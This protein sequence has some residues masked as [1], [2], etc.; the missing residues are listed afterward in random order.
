[1]QLWSLTCNSFCLLSFVPLIQIIWSL[2]LSHELNINSECFVNTDVHALQ[3]KSITLITKQ[4]ALC[5]SHYTAI[6]SFFFMFCWPCVSIHPCNENQLDTLF[7]LSLFRQSTST[8]FGH[9]FSPS[10]GGILYTVYTKQLVRVVL[11]SCNRQ[12]TKKH[13]TYQLLYIYNIPPDDG[14]QICPKH[15]EVDWRNK[16]RINS[17]S[18]WF[19]L[20]R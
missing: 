14:L 11:F 2:R 3:T 1:M 12:L 15:V 10:S 18:S 6:N 7:I 16:L 13:N 17:V 19:S 9:I 8:C 20:H 4:T 5:I